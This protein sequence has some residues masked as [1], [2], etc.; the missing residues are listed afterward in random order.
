MN[1]FYKLS[2][3]RYQYRRGVLAN[4]V[5]EPVLPVPSSYILLDGYVYFALMQQFWN[6]IDEEDEITYQEYL[7][8]LR[9]EKPEL[10]DE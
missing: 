8:V 1:K 6:S 2:Y 3:S 5:G 10:F 9:I 7:D 4:Q